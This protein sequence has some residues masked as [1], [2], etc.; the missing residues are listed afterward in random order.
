M[1]SQNL[2]VITVK[3]SA[4]IKYLAEKDE[5]STEDDEFGDKKYD[6]LEAAPH[7]LYTDV[8]C[9]ENDIYA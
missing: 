3:S 2:E 8:V 7:G 6:R 5:G 4:A 1:F 9:P